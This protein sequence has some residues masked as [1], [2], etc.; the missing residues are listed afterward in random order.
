MSVG[1]PAGHG[2][3]SRIGFTGYGC[4]HAAP[5]P[6]AMSRDRARFTMAASIKWGQINISGQNDLSP[7]PEMFI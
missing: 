2:I 3:T 4:A 6:K 1:P 5:M 7:S